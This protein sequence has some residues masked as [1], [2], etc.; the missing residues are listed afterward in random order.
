ME[1][2]K[3]PLGI[4][5]FEEIRTQGFYYI[6]KSMLIA[7]L[8]NGWSK[9]NLFTRPRRFGKTLNMSMLQSFFEVG[10]DTKLFEG[11]DIVKE[12]ALCD[13]YMGKFPV[14]FISLKGIDGA[15]YQDA[16]RKLAN[17]IIREAKRLRFL[18]DSSVLTIDEKEDYQGLI[19]G[20]FGKYGLELALLTLM[21]LLYRHYDK[22]VILLIDEYDVP[23]EKAHQRGYYRDM[24]DTIRSMFDSALKTNDNLQFAV[25]SGCLRVS[26]ESIFTGLNN[27]KI[28]SISDAS[29]D[30]YFGFTEDEVQTMLE[31]YKIEKHRDTFKEWYDGYHFGEQDVYCPWDVLNY[32]YDLGV[33][34]KAQPK[35]YWLNTSGNDKVRRLI[36]MA[37]T[38][39]AQ[40]EIE[41]LIAGQTIRKELND[42][43]THEEIDKNIRNLWSLLFMT[44]Y[45]TMVGTPNG[46]VFEL[47]IPNKEVRQIFTQQVLKWFNDSVSVDAVLTELY[48]AFE[49]GNTEKIE[50]ILNQKLLDTI[51]YHDDYESFYHGFLMALLSA[52][53]AWSAT[54]NAE[55]GKGRS[56]IRVERKDRKL[57]FIVEVKHV[58]DERKMDEKSKEALQQ[59]IDKEYVAPLKRYKVRDIWMYG[60][61]FCDKECRVIAKKHVNQLKMNDGSF[62]E[63]VLC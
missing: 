26:K 46:N 1:T 39:T 3:I 34:P 11:L 53:A 36:E 57:G 42:Q 19:D 8:L 35:T 54:S 31:E 15:T 56:D 14:V 37:D 51:S 12:K 43:L 47:A 52:C 27:P 38:G 62:A 21:S 33:S 40:M 5:N 13:E 32:A 4:E 45:L 24:L 7:D 17:I 22:K 16:E 30:E 50:E 18:Q 48:T 55:S 59:I 25:L 61:T 2:R 41:D 58:K 20:S 49:T 23:L 44:G 28:H 63:N 9:V 6:D 29:F 10:T 60:I